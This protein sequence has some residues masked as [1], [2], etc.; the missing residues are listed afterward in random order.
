MNK[1][2][3]LESILQENSMRKFLEDIYK[4]TEAT[5]GEGEEMKHYILCTA[6]EWNNHRLSMEH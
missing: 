6:R 4:K 1:W 5:S 3:R 2:D